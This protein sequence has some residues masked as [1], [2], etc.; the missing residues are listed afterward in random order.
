MKK[1]PEA[2]SQALRVGQHP[3]FPPLAVRAAQIAE[4]D[5]QTDAIDHLAQRGPWD[6]M[7][8]V[9]LCDFVRRNVNL[10]FEFVKRCQ[11]E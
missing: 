11:F 7:A 1:A 9:D 2:H 3:I 8:F 5:P 6:P 4:D 10:Y